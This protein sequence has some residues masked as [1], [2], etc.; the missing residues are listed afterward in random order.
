MHIETHEID[1]LI[2]CVQEVKVVQEVLFSEKSK[3]TIIFFDQRML[4]KLIQ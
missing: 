1:L 4:Y 2:S 3:I